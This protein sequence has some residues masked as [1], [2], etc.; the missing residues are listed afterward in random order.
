[1][2]VLGLDLGTK[3]GWAVGDRH[4]KI[5]YGTWPLAQR[6]DAGGIR[7]VRFIRHVEEITLGADVKQIVYERVDGHKGVYAAQIYGGFKDNLLRWCEDNGMPCEG[8]PVGTIK[9]YWT[10]RGN[11]DKEAMKAE[12]LR[13]GYIID[14]MDD[15]AIDALAIAHWSIT[16][17]RSSA[18]SADEMLS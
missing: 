5:V 8:I 15:N 7:L 6:G 4:E 13:R 11:A 10:G 17:Y 14:K 16:Q 9:K 3:C 18:P 2:T 1:V 12:A